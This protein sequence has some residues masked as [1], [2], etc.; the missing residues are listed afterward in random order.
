MH[1]AYISHPSCL[2]HEM[3][4]DHPESPERL[5]S[6]ADRLLA[7]GVLDY[8]QTYTAPSATLEQI[9]RAHTSHYIDEIFNTAPLSGYRGIDPDTCM[10]Q[11]TLEAARHA[12]GALVLA[13]DLVLR[14]EVTRAFCAV[15]PPGHH[16][17]S[18]AAMGFC[19]FNNIAIG[20]HHAFQLH[21]LERILL[22]DFDVHHGN[23]SEEIFANDSRVLMVSTFQ[24]QLYPFSGEKP[25]GSN[26]VNVP[27]MT[28]SQGEAMRLA[29]EEQWWPAVRDFQPQLIYVSAGFDAHIEDDMGNLGW[30][31]ADYSWLTKQLV[32]MSEEYC[33]GRLISTLEGGYAIPALSRCVENHVRILADIH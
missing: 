18:D 25:L 22:V 5:S 29:V 19:F 23:G 28:R 21:D 14:K 30:R 26:M 16:A 7:R 11:H 27:L 17:E 31:D 9:G 12:A 6:I 3:G 20:I 32:Q 24:S 33:E 10:N 4:I 13:T 2:R 15:R 8:L 1:T